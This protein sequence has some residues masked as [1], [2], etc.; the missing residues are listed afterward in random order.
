MNTNLLDLFGTG[1][2]LVCAIG[3]GGKKTT[4]Y[5]LAGNHSGRVAVT[6]SVFVTHFPS[7][8]DAEIIVAPEP[9]IAEEVLRSDSDRVA[10]AC[11]S[12]KKGRY[13]GVPAETISRLHREGRFD[14]T[15]IKA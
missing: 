2:G 9:R 15:L 8:L 6:A 4:L 10:Y 12:D 5:A 13:A 3:A 11:P 1:S 14:V 7:E